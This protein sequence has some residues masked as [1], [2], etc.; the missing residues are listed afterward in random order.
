MITDKIDLTIA[1]I[2]NRNNDQ[3]IEAL[4]SAQFAKHILIL[5]N[6]SE[7]DW[8]DLKTKFQ[9]SVISHEN[10][11]KS[12]SKVRNEMLEHVKTNWVLFLDSDE[13]LGK[14]AR[15]NS[16]KEIIEKI[17]KDDLFDGV[18]IIRRDVF[19]DQ[20][21]KYGEAG[22]QNITRLFKTKKGKFVRNVH[23]VAII[24][25]NLGSSEIIVSHFS[26]SDISEFIT[27]ISQYAKM[28]SKNEEDI[29]LIAILKM[30][31]YPLLKFLY[32]YILKLGFLDGYRG[33]I[34]AI[35]MSLHS[36]FVRVFYFEKKFSQIKD[37]NESQN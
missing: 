35:I 22:N 14:G 16:N 34:Y 5:D 21:L 33:L 17:I 26:H 15:G 7:N 28:S 25:G 29:E 1:I 10:Q 3:F 12:F 23:E 2:T 4:D 18:N 24:N 31:F 9:F 13:S 19:K 37:T 20:E 11:I 6:N 27:K 32:N 36:L 30:I 8:K